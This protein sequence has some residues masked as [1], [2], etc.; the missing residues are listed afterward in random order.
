MDE[1]HKPGDENKYNTHT[2]THYCHVVERFAYSNITVISHGY[3]E[4]HFTASEK[5][6]KENLGQAGIKG[7]SLVLNQKVC[8]HFGSSK[9][10]NTYI[11]KREVR[12]Q[13]VHG[14]MK[15]GI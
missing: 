4:H 11:Y 8:N 7:N 5:V 3:K 13:K 6:N 2:A 1:P 9:R 15:A 12:K 10:G 14:G